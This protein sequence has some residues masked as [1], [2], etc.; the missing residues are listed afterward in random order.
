MSM[1]LG[2][3]GSLPVTLFSAL[4]WI[5]A[6]VIKSLEVIS[7][8]TCLHLGPNYF[9]PKAMLCGGVGGVGAT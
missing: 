2:R 7:W 3:L 8:N 1:P 4:V 6:V 5:L 9:L